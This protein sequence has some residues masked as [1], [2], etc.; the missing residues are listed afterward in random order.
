MEHKKIHAFP[1][2]VRCEFNFYIIQLIM[3]I[4]NKGHVTELN[5]SKPQANICNLLFRDFAVPKCIGSVLS[6]F[7]FKTS[8]AF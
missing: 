2:L 3:M 6:S 4:N 7:L 1:V 5:W 8:T